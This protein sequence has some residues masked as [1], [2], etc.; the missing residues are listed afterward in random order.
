[1]TT[2]NLDTIIASAKALSDARADILRMTQALSAAMEALKADQMPEI[3]AQIDRAEA[4]W[5]HLEAQIRANPDLFVKPRTLAAHGIS[6]GIQRDKPAIVIADEARTVRLLR[7]HLT[8]E[9]AGVA[10]KVTETPVK[11]AL[12][13]LP[14]D[15]LKRV[16]VD[17][18]AGVDRVV[19]RP[20]ETEVDKM[21]KALIKAKVEEGA[22]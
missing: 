7:K 19:I 11:K 12:E 15:V 21:V 14:A 17:L 16:G 9:Q 5:M 6:F 13:Q 20:A 10:I 4:A 22:S 8:E 3:R 18:V 1:M 2:T